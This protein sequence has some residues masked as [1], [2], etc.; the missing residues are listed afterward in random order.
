MKNPERHF[1]LARIL[2]A[3]VTSASLQS[4]AYL[5]L[6]PTSHEVEDFGKERDFQFPDSIQSRINIEQINWA[7]ANSEFFLTFRV[8]DPER[9]YESITF[10]SLTAR[11]EDGDTQNLVRPWKYD[12]DTRPWDPYYFQVGSFSFREKSVTASFSGYL[13]SRDGTRTQFSAT[14][15]FRF[16]PR[17]RWTHYP[18][19]E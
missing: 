5:L 10:T 18:M 2:V 8:S 6:P 16:G 19:G 14:E 11:Y 12:F 13:T 7:D 17:R 9:R 3:L 4:C 15:E 1:S